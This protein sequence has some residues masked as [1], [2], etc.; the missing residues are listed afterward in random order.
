MSVL[1]LHRYRSTENLCEWRVRGANKAR[2]A[3]FS[4]ERVGGG[5]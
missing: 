1:P 2:S 5:S 3:K 4:V